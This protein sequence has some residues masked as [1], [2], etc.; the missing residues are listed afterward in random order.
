MKRREE[1]RA[2]LEDRS[3]RALERLIRRVARIAKR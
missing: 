1:V 3:R 2:D